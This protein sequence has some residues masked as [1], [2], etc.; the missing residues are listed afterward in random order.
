MPASSRSDWLPC[1]IPLGVASYLA[2]RCTAFPHS[3]FSYAPGC[4]WGGGKSPGWESGAQKAILMGSWKAFLFSPFLLWSQSR[5]VRLTFL[6][7]TLHLGNWWVHSRAWNYSLVSIPSPLISLT[8]KFFS[9]LIHLHFP[10][11]KCVISPSFY[12]TIRSTYFQIEWNEPM[13][14]SV[15]GSWVCFVLF[16]LTWDS[17]N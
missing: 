10:G 6:L 12:L 7:L 13:W 8:L 2:G 15:E 5:V 11:H 4:C 9:K 3:P 17:G 14:E 1:S 16:C